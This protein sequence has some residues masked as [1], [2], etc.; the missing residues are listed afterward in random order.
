MLVLLIAKYLKY[1]DRGNLAAK[2]E[3]LICAGQKQPRPTAA[4]ILDDLKNI[5]I[6]RLG[7]Q[8]R[9]GSHTR[10][11][12]LIMKCLGFGW[13]LYTEGDCEDKFTR[14]KG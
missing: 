13:E 7:N 2:K 12:D 6:I 3:A 5:V 10:N 14:P 1:R 11:I 9:V 8:S 4:T